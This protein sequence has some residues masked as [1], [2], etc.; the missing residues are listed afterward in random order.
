M[1]FF[2]KLKNAVMK[3][4][5]TKLA[6][7]VVAVAVIGGGTAALVYANVNSSAEAVLGKAV[8]ATFVMQESSAEETFGLRALSA[9]FKENGTELGVEA[10]IEELPLN[11]GMGD[12]T[13]PNVGARLILRTNTVGESNLDADV[14]V[15]NTALLSGKLYADKNKVQVTV[16]KLLKDVPVM[17]YSSE[18]FNEDV[19]NCYL[20]DYLGIPQ[21]TLNEILELLPENTEALNKEEVQR[22]L[23][24]ILVSCI[25]D[26]F[27]E[28]DLEKAGKAELTLGDEVVTC[29]AY[30][31]TIFSGYIREF[32]NNYM[33]LTKN[34]IKELAAGYDVTELEV[35]YAF[36]EVEKAIQFLRNSISDVD[37][38]FY[39]HENRL[40][41]MRAD[42]EMEW[43]LAEPEAGNLEVTF[44]RS[45]NPMENMRLALT[46]PIH[47]DMTASEVPERLELAC[48]VTTENTED[49]YSVE[50][51]A[52][53]NEEPL[54]LSFEY[55]KLG[56]DFVLA[57]EN[58]V[59]LLTV[60]GAIGELE[61]GRKIGLE[62]EDYVYVEGDY[63]EEQELNLS[64]YLK[65]L[66]ETV[67]PLTGKELD[68]VKLT[69]EDVAALEEEARAN[70]YKLVFSMLGLFQ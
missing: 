19:K 20:V 34:Y 27:A 9:A 64:L 37:V 25:G 54:Q 65:V 3:S 13:L 50:W 16:P 33:L 31:A 12:M 40:I 62:L 63:I 69:E 39:V 36:Y 26:C 17:Y 58:S 43:T 15:A 60:T 1:G 41:R 59:Q 46:L 24:E 6:T 56:G 47:G 10:S 4:A 23:L 21:E 66:E 18:T 55:E 35:D 7:A 42:W 53:L 14:T 49:I 44:A 28:V 61:K 8:A 52:V 5:A 29:K 11:L 51:Q 22:K 67:A 45:G 30:S 2:A 32:L 48:N 70:V 38:V 68:V 57:A